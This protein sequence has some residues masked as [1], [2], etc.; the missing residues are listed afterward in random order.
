MGL[1][2]VHARESAIVDLYDMH[3]E[4]VYTWS[5][6]ER[7]YIERMTNSMMVDNARRV[8]VHRFLCQTAPRQNGLAFEFRA[9]FQDP[10][11]E[12]LV[13]T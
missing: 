13:M 6:T 9:A 8:E 10:C 12:C 3:M 4:M 1:S 2:N 11:I 7:N 5:V